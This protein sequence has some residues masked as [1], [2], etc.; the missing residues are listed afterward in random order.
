MSTCPHPHK[1][2]K[3]KQED[4]IFWIRKKNK[5][6]LD[7]CFSKENE[8][9]NTVDRRGWVENWTEQVVTLK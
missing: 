7:K 4:E 8:L 5:R 9:P 6:K 1:K 2:K 3:P